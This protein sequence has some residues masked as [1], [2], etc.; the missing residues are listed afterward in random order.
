MQGGAL[1]GIMLSRSKNDNNIQKP[2]HEGRGGIRYGRAGQRRQKQSGRHA[3][4]NSADRASMEA[5]RALL[6]KLGGSFNVRVRTFRRL[7]NEVLPKLAYLSKQAGIMALTGIIQDNKDKLSCFVRGAETP[8]FVSDMYD[9][10]SMMKYCRIPPQA[11]LE[12][13]LPEGVKGKAHDVECCTR[14]TATFLNVGTSIPP[15]SWSCFARRSKP[16]SR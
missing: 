13:E 6:Q 7:A 4:R 15:T 12:G 8:G 5:E 10:I 2:Q 9:V 14:R 16:P 1:C 11:L 3:H